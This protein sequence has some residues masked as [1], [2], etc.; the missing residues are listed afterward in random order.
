MRKSILAA[1]LLAGSL[2]AIAQKGSE[3][4]LKELEKNQ[5]AYGVIAQQI[6]DYAEMGYLEEQSS[7]LL[8]KT[9]SDEGFT[10]R[11]G[12]A[13]IPT[14][15]IAEYGSGKPVVAILGEYDALPGLSQ[16]RVPEQKSAGKAAGHACGHHRRCQ[17]P[18]G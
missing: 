13:G 4:L 17:L 5:E 18:G 10:I 3:S 1:L 8:Q 11:K 6:W 12:V 14:A 9:L 7:A 15:F 2:T 16:E